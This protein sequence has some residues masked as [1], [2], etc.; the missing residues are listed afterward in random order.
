MTPLPAALGGT[1]FLVWRLDQGRFGPTWDSGE[2]AYR[3]GG[4]W[5]SKGV[6]AV[7][8]S[9][10]PSTAI[11]EVAVHKG[12]RTLDTIPHVMTAVVITDA[13]DVHVVDPGAVPN[14]NWLRPGIPSA[15]QQA[16][17]DDLLQ[18]HRFVAIPSA[19]SSHSWNFVF[20]ASVAAGAYALKLQ[21][22]FALDTRLHPPAIP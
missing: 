5:N 10:D 21:E 6:R 8:C 17:G 19:V 11:L 16:F 1:E 13:T 12:F 7:Y 15:G 20:V 4:R 9:I 14:P 18:R 2:G 3:V 22:L